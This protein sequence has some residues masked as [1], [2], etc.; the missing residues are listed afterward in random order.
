MKALAFVIVF[1]GVSAFAQENN[2]PAMVDIQPEAQSIETQT[3]PE[4]VSQAEMQSKPTATETETVTATVTA[5]ATALAPVPVPT[6]KAVSQPAEQMEVSSKSASEGELEKLNYLSMAIQEDLKIMS[7][8]SKEVVETT[9]SIGRMM[10]KMRQ[11][12]VKAQQKPIVDSNSVVNPD[13]GALEKLKSKFED[14]KDEHWSRFAIPNFEYRF[15]KRDRDLV[16]VQ[17][18]VTLK[19]ILEGITQ[20]RSKFL[21]SGCFNTTSKSFNGAPICQKRLAVCGQAGFESQEK[22]LVAHTVNS[23]FKLEAMPL[24]TPDDAETVLGNRYDTTSDRSTLLSD[25]TFYFCKLA[26][27]FGAAFKAEPFL[28]PAE[29]A[30]HR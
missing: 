14:F 1:A 10:M 5:T 2:P 17:N 4:P 15:F 18:P 24:D 26:A 22:Q 19:K 9:S 29:V 27:R 11:I 25:E 3:A 30:A 20:A 23:E 8:N 16:T 13:G 21:P 7:A 6:S 12:D 28:Y